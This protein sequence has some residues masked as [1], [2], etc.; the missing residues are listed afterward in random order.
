MPFLGTI[1]NFVGVIIA[2]VLGALVKKG[3][4]KRI[5]ETVI[6]AVGVCVVFIG[7]DGALEAAPII[8]ETD[9]NGLAKILIMIISM[10]VGALLGELIDVDRLITKLG[11]TLEA[12]FASDAADSQKGNFAK[13]FVSCSILFCVGAMAVNGG[14]ED[15]MGSPDILIAKTVIDCISCFL[16]AASL[17]IGCAFSAL[18]LLVYQ[19]A[20]ALLGMFLSTSGIVPASTITYMSVTG[21]L[22]IIL[23]GTNM[24]GATKVKTANMIPAI[25]MPAAICPLFNLIF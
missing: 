17:G 13:G 1:I 22:I 5:T 18:T 7:I 8:S 19:G 14:I 11:N 23:I 20:F 2:G 9:Y 15:G 16:M 12:R 21:S 4:P 10:A 25:F 3:I 6:Y 24:L